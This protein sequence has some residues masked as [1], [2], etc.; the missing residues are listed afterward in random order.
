MWSV[1]VVLLSLSSL[2]NAA[3]GDSIAAGT[4]SAL[5]VSTYAKV[6]SSSCYILAH[7]PRIAFNHVVISAGIND[8]PGRCVAALLN[9]VR[10]RDVVVILP[11]PINSA[12]AH[13]A[14]L[15]AKH[16]VRTVSY[17]CTGGCTKHN[18]HPGS[19]LAVARAV[20]ELWNEHD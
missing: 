1:L 19:Y 3:L 6:G 12:R 14:R 5:G 4:G 2:P 9:R 11:A 15:A 8:A 10:A 20:R 13:V 16:G 17:T 18:F 7:T